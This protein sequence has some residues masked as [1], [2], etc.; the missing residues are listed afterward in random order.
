MKTLNEPGFFIQQMIGSARDL[1]RHK[2]ALRA[3]VAE[4]LNS[5]IGRFRL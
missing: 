1:P 5:Q 3:G 2:P 4:Q